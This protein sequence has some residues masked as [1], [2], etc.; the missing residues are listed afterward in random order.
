VTTATFQA[1]TEHLFLFLLWDPLLSCPLSAG[2]GFI[3][4]GGN[5]QASQC[6]MLKLRARTNGRIVEGGP[7]GPEI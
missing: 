7:A 1:S 4:A 3:K 2:E 5:A 6:C